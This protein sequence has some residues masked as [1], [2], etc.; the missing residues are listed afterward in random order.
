MVL[1]NLN[2]PELSDRLPYVPEEP[3]HSLANVFLTD[4]EWQ[5]S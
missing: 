1:Y 5:G 3:S 2:I 4:V